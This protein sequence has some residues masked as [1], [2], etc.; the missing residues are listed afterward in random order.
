LQYAVRR[1]PDR[2]F[3]Q[4]RFE[5]LVDFWIGE[6]RTSPQINRETALHQ[7][8][9]CFGKT[10][11]QTFLDAIPVLKVCGEPAVPAKEAK[12][13]STIQRFRN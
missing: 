13:L 10:P 1:Q 5:E 11:I 3:D 12:I 9:C 4:L 8:R 2:V 6:A 7:G